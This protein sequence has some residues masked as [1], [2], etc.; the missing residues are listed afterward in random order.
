MIG[1]GMGGM[2]WYWLFG[3][4]LLLGLALLVVVAVRGLGGGVHRG[5]SAATRGQP[6]GRSQAREVLDERYARGELSTEEYR[7]RLHGLGEDT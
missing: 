7:E 3:P 4:I 2:G 6:P 1:N 5:D